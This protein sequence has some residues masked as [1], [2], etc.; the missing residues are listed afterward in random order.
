MS[1]KERLT[2][3]LITPEKTLFSQEVDSV[4]A[5]TVDGQVT[6]LDHH[7]PLISILEPGELIVEDHGT[8]FPLAVSA[9]V[10]E[11]SDNTL[12]IMADTAEHAKEIDIQET[13]KRAEKMA[14][15]LRTKT[16]MDMTTYNLLQRRFEAERA[17]VAVARKWR[18]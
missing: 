16:R 12:V 7:S 2:L 4:I 15:Q 14:K 17:K 11:V 18:R 3:K 5:N 1:S 9:G 10:L 8:T 6:V 13:E